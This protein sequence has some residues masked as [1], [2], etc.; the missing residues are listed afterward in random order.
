[1]C[2]E[3]KACRYTDGVHVGCTR[4]KKAR[5]GSKGFGPNNQTESYT[6]R[7]YGKNCRGKGN[8][9][10]SFEH[11]EMFI[12]Y[13]SGNVKQAVGRNVR[14]QGE[15]L[16]RDKHLGIVSITIVLEATIPAGTLEKWMEQRAGDEVFKPTSTHSPGN[17]VGPAKNLRSDQKCTEGKP[18]GGARR[19]PRGNDF[20]RRHNHLS[21]TQLLGQ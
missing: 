12:G 1:M 10:L 19:K 17:Q 9:E 13:P 2:S 4:K 20:P 8:Q 16:A 15:I 5:K 7:W 6:T 18:G 11:V 14:V 21:R 3:G